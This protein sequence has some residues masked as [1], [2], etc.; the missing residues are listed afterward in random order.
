MSKNIEDMVYIYT[1][2]YDIFYYTFQ[3]D[4]VGELFLTAPKNFNRISPDNIQYS[5]E[6]NSLVRVV[7]EKHDSE[8]YIISDRK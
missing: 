2:E 8:L 5:I 1:K 4:Y 3:P 6:N 7:I